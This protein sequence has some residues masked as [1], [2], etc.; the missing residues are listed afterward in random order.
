MVASCRSIN[1]DQTDQAKHEQAND[2]S[3]L[4]SAK[5]ISTAL[6]KLSPRID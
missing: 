3:R 6:D 4:I 1:A 5:S 2:H